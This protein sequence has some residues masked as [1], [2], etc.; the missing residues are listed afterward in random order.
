MKNISL[1]IFLLIGIS[2]FCI[3]SLSIYTLRG[4]EGTVIVL[5]SIIAYCAIVGLAYILKQ[6]DML[7][8]QK[9]NYD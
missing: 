7:E 1:F 6:Y 5:L 4:Y 3:V 9:I 2:I 8:R